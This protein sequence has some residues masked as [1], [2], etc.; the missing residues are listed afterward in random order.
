MARK[1]SRRGE[2]ALEAACA[3]ASRAWDA[4][5]E[6]QV[7]LARQALA[8][9][10]LCVEAHVLLAK[11]AGKG[12]PEALAHWRRAVGAGAAAIGPAGFREIASGRSLPPYVG[13]YIRALIGLAEALREKGDAVEALET[14]LRAFDA[15]PSDEYAIGFVLLGWLIEDG[16][17]VE[18]AVLLTRLIRADEEETGPE[19]TWG[20]A[21]L[22]FRASGDS[23][24]L[25][26]I[27]SDAVEANGL[28]GPA[29][30]GAAPIAD[31]ATVGLERT[32]AMDAFLVVDS[33]GAAWRKTPGAI[34]WLAERLSEM[35]RAG[36]PLTPDAPD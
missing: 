23:E 30:T 35:E 32:D 28:I 14:M 2:R 4:E 21:L 9:S 29:L 13:E 22:D 34:E 24:E 8:M 25:R 26:A 36:G 1:L 17:D 10:P 31:E 6:E 12:T 18:A 19:W 11:H 16:Q 20:M 33:L 15:D 7:A 5:G 27:L 3:L